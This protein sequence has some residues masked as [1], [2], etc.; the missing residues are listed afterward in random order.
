MNLKDKKK[1]EAETKLR[2]LENE[3][4]ILLA[5][6]GDQQ[7]IVDCKHDI[8]KQRQILQNLKGY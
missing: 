1:Q 5:T 2:R 6:N 3:L 8:Q 7:R 4:R